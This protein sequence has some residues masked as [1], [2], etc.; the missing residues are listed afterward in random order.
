MLIGPDGS[1]KTT[2]LRHLLERDDLP[3]ERR[4]LV[5][6]SL[7]VLPRLDRIVSWWE[8]RHPTQPSA[9]EPEGRHS[10]MFRPLP[11]WKSM[12]IATYH[13]FDM[14]LGRSRLRRP[15]PEPWLLLFDR[16]FYDYSILRGHGNL[17]AW[18][19]G[20]LSHLVPEPDLLLFPK[21]DPAQI[22]RDKPELSLDEIRRQQRAIESLLRSL[23]FG[24]ILHA[25][26]GIEATV[27]QAVEAI[28][29]AADRSLPRK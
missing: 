8:R 26:G 15:R 24:Q 5:R 4:Q 10:A 9:P 7:F 6:E 1:G 29:R 11:A 2:V 17:P 28:R 20:L 19:L 18:Y 23:P 16:S 13:A 14:F 21:R 22:Y 3:F 12:A 27:G 25:D